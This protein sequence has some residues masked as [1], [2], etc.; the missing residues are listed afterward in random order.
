[1]CPS[2]RSRLLIGSLLLLA[3]TALVGGTSPSAAA[4]VARQHS[5]TPSQLGPKGAPLRIRI[6]TLFP[7]FIQAPEYLALAQGFYRE[8]GLEVELQ[9]HASTRAAQDDFLA[10]GSEVLFP[11]G[12]ELLVAIEAGGDA[13]IVGA[14]TRGPTN[15]MAVR[16]DVNHLSDLYGRTVGHDGPGGALYTAMRALF[17]AENADFERA[18]ALTVGGTPRLFDAL[19][20]GSIDGAAVSVDVADQ[21]ATQPSLKVLYDT[22]DQL[23]S[24]PGS[25]YA[26][27]GRVLREQPAIVEKV[28][29]GSMRGIRYALEHKNE[30][31]ASEVE[32]TG[33]SPA[34]LAS[35]YDR[36]T[37]LWDPDAVVTVDQ[38]NY[39]QALNVRLGLQAA[40]VPLDRVADL[41]IHDR[42]LLVAGPYRP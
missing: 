26:V 21:I 37:K 7:L 15:V 4:D 10:G 11:S 32:R 33:G 12:G 20:D 24:Y 41:S 29:V 39:L 17:E 27:S 13:R 14:A 22:A 8:Q 28:L 23:P 25:T 6:N 1:M 40:V 9:H 16:R 42:A 5:S 19:V 38:L 18:T 34:Q 36:Y 30:L 2:P 35:V 31:V 3:C